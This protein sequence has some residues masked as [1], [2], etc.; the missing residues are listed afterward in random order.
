MKIG[1]VI[2]LPSL[3]YLILEDYLININSA[4]VS[5]CTCSNG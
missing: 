4:T 2:K 1:P 5:F 3:V